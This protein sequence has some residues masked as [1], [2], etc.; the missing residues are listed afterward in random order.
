MARIRGSRQLLEHMLA[1]QQQAMPVPLSGD[2]GGTQRRFRRTRRGHGFRLL[3]LYRLALPSSRHAGI[4]P[5]RATAD[6][7]RTSVK[8][9]AEETARSSKTFS[10]FPGLFP[11]Y[12]GYL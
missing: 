11:I 9:L 3:L 10:I 4:I 5:A 7:I 12:L 8:R 1:G 2:L 6:C